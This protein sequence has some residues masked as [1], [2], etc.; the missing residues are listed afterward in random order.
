[1]HFIISD[2]C[3]ACPKATGASD[4]RATLTGHRGPQIQ[5][6]RISWN[7]FG[8]DTVTRDDSVIHL[9]DLLHDQEAVLQKVL[10]DWLGELARHYTAIDSPLPK[11]FENLHSWW[12]LSLSEKNYAT[13]PEFTTL[14]KFMLLS[15]LC[16]EHLPTSVDYDGSDRQLES[17]VR[18]FA[19]AREC[20]T[21]ARRPPYMERIS[22][23]SEPLQA[24]VHFLRVTRHAL[25]NS[26]RR[27]NF[28]SPVFS[29]VGYLIPASGELRAQSPYWGNLPENLTNHGQLLWLYH[30]SDEMPLRVARRYCRVKD[31]TSTNEVHRV[32]DDCI[33]LG[34]L[35]RA[36]K[37]YFSWRIARRELRLNSAGVS[38]A[39]KR[40]PVDA[41]FARQMRDS[42]TGSRAVSTIIQ[43][44]VYEY[45]VCKLPS[46]NWLYLW[47]NK[48][49]EHALVSA[50][51][52][53]SHKSS[54]GYAHSVIRRLDHR[55]FDETH[56]SDLDNA[57]RRP[58]P[59]MYAVNSSVAHE[60]LRRLGPPK[61]R[62]VEVEALRYAPLKVTEQVRP[63]RLLVLGDISRT[64]SERLLTLTVSAVERI[65]DAPKLWFKP[66]PGSPSHSELALKLGFS[67]TFDH[68]SALAPDL[69]LAIVGVAGAASVDLTLLAVPVITM[70]DAKTPNLSPL[71]GISG[72]NFAR[73]ASQL[74]VF[75]KM[76]QLHQIP[77]D[78]L[79][80]RSVTPIRWLNLVNSL[81]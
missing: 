64:E 58:T 74:S 46:T 78:S 45:L 1:V 23:K 68:L 16:D 33:T 22:R 5:Y 79:A 27:V 39:D 30:R 47:E 38:N 49:F 72:A 66:H 17:A 40:L 20:Q 26:F 52:R 81:P 55:Y 43:T 77:A 7:T 51:S 35:S 73:S 41:L 75:I 25:M 59:T 32:I 70:L 28:G 24:V 18:E 57:R 63:V 69:L 62:V 21:N 61:T 4:S 48:P 19:E 10:Y 60:H 14:M 71:A 36:L 65:P 9:G 3:G 29:L 15:K 31:S 54:I 8:E 80:H 2:D 53:H 42:L 34:A 37:T 56:G 44:H 76:P 13:T 67:V 6:L 12:L 50:V 11:V